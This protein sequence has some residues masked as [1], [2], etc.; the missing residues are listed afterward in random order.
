[1]REEFDVSEVYTTFDFKGFLFK[2][3]RFWP[4]FLVSLGI[5]FAIARFINVRKLPVYLIDNNF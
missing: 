1:M 4:L 5:A 3:I 2:L